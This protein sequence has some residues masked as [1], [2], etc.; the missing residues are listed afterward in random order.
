MSRVVIFFLASVFMVILVDQMWAFPF[1]FNYLPQLLDS[2]AAA[3]LAGSEIIA[4]IYEL[5]YFG[6]LGK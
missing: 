4:L 3:L 2:V 5:H 1:L 6:A